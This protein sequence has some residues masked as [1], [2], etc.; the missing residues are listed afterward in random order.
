[1]KCFNWKRLIPSLAASAMVAAATLTPLPG[2]LTSGNAYA[3]HARP[4]AFVNILKARI[5]DKGAI[6]KVQYK[7]APVL[8]NGT[9]SYAGRITLQL[10]QPFPVNSDEEI[11]AATVF[12]NDQ[13][14]Q[15]TVTLHGFANTPI[16]G[17]AVATA[18]LFDSAGN[19]VADV[20]DEG[21]IE[22]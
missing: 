3:F 16:P 19:R 12:C 9:P 6:V 1:M 13:V 18:T 22:L 10:S 7:C 4:S 5:D 15:T 17:Q 14:N 2:F 20:S 8:V 11:N 21:P